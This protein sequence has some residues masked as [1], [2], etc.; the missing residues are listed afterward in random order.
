MIIIS[1]VKTLFLVWVSGVKMILR[2][3]LWIFISMFNSASSEDKKESLDDYQTFSQIIGG[4]VIYTLAF[5]VAFFLA[6]IFFM[7]A[8]QMLLILD[9]A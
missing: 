8:G 9:L 5:V 2:G 7:G 4:C 3:Y 1:G 6:I